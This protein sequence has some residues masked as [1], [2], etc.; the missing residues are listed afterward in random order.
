MK[1]YRKKTLFPGTLSRTEAPRPRPVDKINEPLPG[2]K[3]SRSSFP[4]HPYLPFSYWKEK[5]KWNI[6]KP[7]VIL[8]PGTGFPFFQIPEIIVFLLKR[9]TK[10]NINK[11]FSRYRFS[12]PFLGT[13]F[14]TYTTEIIISRPE[15]KTKMKHK[16]KPFFKYRFLNPFPSTLFQTYLLK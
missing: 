5:T 1:R 13:L 14:Q 16:I 15:R 9:E 7:F 4:D 3:T 11:P 12:H 6:D 2:K 10:W 8:S